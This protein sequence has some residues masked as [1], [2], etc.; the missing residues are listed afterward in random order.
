VASSIR[1]FPREGLG[2]FL[3]LLL[4]LIPAAALATGE[5]WE[6]AVAADDSGHIY[7]LYPQ[8]GVV[9]DGPADLAS[10]M[11]S[12][13]KDGGLT[14]EPS[15]ALTP[16][17]SSQSDPQIAID[18]G[19]DRTVY[20]TWLQN[21][22]RDVIVA[23]STDFGQSWSLA[24]ATRSPDPVEKPVLAVRGRDVY[25]AFTFGNTL[26]AAA[27]HDGGIS[28]TFAVKVLESPLN[29]ALTG[30]GTVETSGNVFFA[31]E[32]YVGERSTNPQAHLFLSKSS[33]GRIWSTMLMDISGL[34]AGCRAYRCEWGYLGAQIVVASDAGGTLYT[35]WTSRPPQIAT[36]EQKSERIYFAASTTGGMTWAPRQDLSTAPLG[37]R[38][39]L[40]FIAAKAAGEVR[41]GWMDSRRSPR[42]TGYIR[43][44]TSGGAVWS[45]EEAIITDPQGMLLTHFAPAF[46]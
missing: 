25:A 38:H 42:W 10:I 43:T 28:F 11:L 15:R 46:P 1:R 30:N 40:P 29:G 14:W 33:D 16:P 22:G 4:S 24:L 37:A 6:P 7:I 32:G 18:P 12:L 21:G 34:P 35:L 27:S 39:V 8:I 13:S 45:D 36:L 31:W 2:I 44:S 26:W 5:Q 20:A 9:P 17:I 19:D 3:F 41:V 23:K